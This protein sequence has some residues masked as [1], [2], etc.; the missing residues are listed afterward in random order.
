MNAGCNGVFAGG[1]GTGVGG[2]GSGG[3]P[4]PLTLEAACQGPSEEF[5]TRASADSLPDAASSLSLEDEYGPYVLSFCAMYQ[6]RAMFD[7]VSRLS[8]FVSVNGGGNGAAAK[9][10]DYK[11]LLIGDSR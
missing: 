6:S 5:A 9:N 11:T 3:M 1:A 4:S 2:A 10:N 7:V 8:V